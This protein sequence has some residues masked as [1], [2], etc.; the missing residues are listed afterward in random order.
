MAASD[1]KNFYLLFCLMWSY[2]KIWDNNKNFLPSIL[3]RYKTSL[4][5]PGELSIFFVS[6][7]FK[8]T[9]NVHGTDKLIRL[10]KQKGRILKGQVNEF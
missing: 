9:E 7:H 2:D 10:L 3:P 8:F 1:A 6:Y 4:M 5:L